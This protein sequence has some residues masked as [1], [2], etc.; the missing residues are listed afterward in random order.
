M[1]S[2]CLGHQ[3]R[4]PVLDK[5]IR[6]KIFLHIKEN[7]LTKNVHIDFINGHIDHV[8]LLVSLNA[9]QTIANTVQLIKGESSYWIN[10]NK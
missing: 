10:K 3:K 1:G 4:D 8:H 2:S 7:A 9:D 5:D 6:K